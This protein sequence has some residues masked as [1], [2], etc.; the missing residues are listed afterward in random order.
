V[1]KVLRTW[2]VVGLPTVPISDPEPAPAL[3]TVRL[4]M[5]VCV[6]APEVPVTVS[7]EVLT[8]VDA[9][10]VMFSVEVPDP[11][12]IVAGLNVAVAPLGNP[13]ID[14]TVFPVKPFSGFTVMVYVVPLPCATD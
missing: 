5:A 2:V 9:M 3:V 7:V 14:N 10:V 1:P 4:T 8:G 13:A 6:I 11:A 12:V